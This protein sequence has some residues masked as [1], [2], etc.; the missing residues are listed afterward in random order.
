VEIQ[1]QRNEHGQ[2]LTQDDYTSVV[3]W[4]QEEP[5]RGFNLQ[6]FAGRVAPS[7]AAE[8]EK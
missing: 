1:D 6:R 2:V 8:Y 7:Q 3:S 4:Y 5:H